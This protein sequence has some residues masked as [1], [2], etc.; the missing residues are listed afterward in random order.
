[1]VFEPVEGGVDEGEGRITVGLFGAIG[2]CEAF[3][4]VAGDALFGRRSY[5]VVRIWVEI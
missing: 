5:F 3:A 4:A 2:P 1:M